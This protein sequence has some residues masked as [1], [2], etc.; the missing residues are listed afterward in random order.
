MK[1][2]RL[3][4]AV[5]AAALTIS[6]NAVADTVLP[7]VT[8][9][10][11]LCSQQIRLVGEQVLMFQRDTGGWPKNVDMATPLTDPEMKA[12]VS[13]THLTLPTTSRV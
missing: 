2:F 4:A 6:F 9:S 11:S 10:A 12:A 7:S 1:I 3:G 5:A 13:Y 8:D